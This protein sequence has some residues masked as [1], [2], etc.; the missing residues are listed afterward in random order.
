MANLALLTLYAILA[1]TGPVLEAQNP[2]VE[3]VVTGAVTNATTGAPLAG[4]QVSIPAT[5]HGAMTDASGRYRLTAPD[6]LRGR[7]VRLLVQ[8]LGYSSVGRDVVLH[9]DSVH[10]DFALSQARWGLEAIVTA[11]PPP[12]PAPPPPSAGMRLPFTVGRTSPNTEGYDRIT[13]NVFRSVA[14]EPLSTFSIDVDRASYSDV[15][16]FLRLG[17]MPPVDA[18]R[19]EEMI[20]Y[21]PYRATRAPDGHPFA[22]ITEVTPTPWQSRHLLARI[23][24]FAPPVELSD[25]PPA[26]FVFLVDVSGSMQPANKLPLLKQSLRLLINELRPQDRVALVVYAGRAGMVLESTPG[27][28]KERILDAIGSLEAGGSTA[29]GAGIQL[30]YEIAGQHHIADGNNRVILATDGDF[31]VGVSSDAEMVRLIEEKRAQGTFLTVLGFGMGNIKHDKLEKLADHGN[32]NYAYIDDLMEAR[33]VLIEEMGGTLLTVAKDVKLQ[34]EFN[35]EHVRAYRLIGYENRVLANADFNND[36][37]DAGDLGAGHTVTALYELVPAG[38]TGTIELHEPDSLRYQTPRA[39][40]DTRRNSELAFVKLR[41][42]EPD[43]TTSRLL[44]IPIGA[45]ASTASDDFRFAAAVASFGM[46][47]RKSPHRGS[48]TY[49]SVIAAAGGALGDDPGGYRR[50]FVRLVEAAYAVSKMVAGR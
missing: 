42:K 36:A 40:S 21:F 22:V 23:S 49:E 15:R 41:Y 17:Q 32:G 6:S 35:P 44:D 8:F 29:G 1:G 39:S 28:Q 3:I 24:L 33:K 34:V 11:A 31:N 45:R 27:S 30:A 16:R 43:G 47:L 14:A 9:A 19:I 25:M 50:E 18:V 20:N 46:L 26:N 2:R 38:V 48:A 5:S 7:T 12:A 10:V 13:E 4:A 37:K